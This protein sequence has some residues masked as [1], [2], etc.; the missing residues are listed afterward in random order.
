M[1]GRYSPQMEESSVKVHSAIEG[2]G[3]SGVR[4]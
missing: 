1:M 3:I 4:H 2:F